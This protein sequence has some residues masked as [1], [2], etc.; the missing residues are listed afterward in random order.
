MI[1]PLA[2]R[3]GETLS[4]TSTMRPSLCR[5]RV[6]YCSSLSPAVTRLRISSTS[7]RR[8][9]GTMMSMRFPIASAAVYPNSSS[10]ARFQPVMVPS[11]DLV[12][13]ASLEDS[14]TALN[15]HSRWLARSLSSAALR[16]TICSRRDSLGLQRHIVDQQHRQHETGGAQSVDAAGIEAEIESGGIED[17]RQP[18][19]NSQA[20][21]TTISQTSRTECGRRNH[22]TA[23]SAIQRNRTVDDHADQDRRVVSVAQ[24]R[25]QNVMSGGDDPRDQR[26]C[27]RDRDEACEDRAA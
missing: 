23:R 20:Q 26:H 24:Q 4:E 5:R 1:S 22:K 16:R 2:D 15:S 18:M 17:R 8:S 11:S 14:T 27:D 3:I 13:I 7:A 21:S 25:G 9:G 10:A 6:S 19:S 12:M